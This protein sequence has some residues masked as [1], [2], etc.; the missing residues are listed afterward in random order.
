[1]STVI[2]YKNLIRLDKKIVDFDMIPS[3]L[4]LMVQFP[5]LC[6]LI[7]TISNYCITNWSDANIGKQLSDHV[8]IKLE[9]IVILKG[10]LIFFPTE[11]EAFGKSQ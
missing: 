2:L 6:I 10:V 9:E 11:Q 7:S 5:L 4:V 3:H 1:M 8:S